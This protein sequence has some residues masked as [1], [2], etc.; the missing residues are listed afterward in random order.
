M[1]NL[2]SAVSESPNGGYEMNKPNLRLYFSTRY[3][4]NSGPLYGSSLYS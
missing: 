3:A 2:E 4:N 1:C